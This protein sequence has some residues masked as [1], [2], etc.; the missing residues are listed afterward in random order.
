MYSGEDSDKFRGAVDW[1]SVFLKIFLVPRYYAVNA[2]GF[3]D[4][5]LHSVLKVFPVP[6]KSR[7]N[8]MLGYGEDADFLP[9]ALILPPDFLTVF[10]S[11]SQDVQYISYGR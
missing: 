8:V 10:D 7:V 1:D 11:P 2:V 3:S 6:R 9:E 5:I 4:G